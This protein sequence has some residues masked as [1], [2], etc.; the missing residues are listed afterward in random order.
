MGRGVRLE[1]KEEGENIMRM[2]LHRW[3]SGKDSACQCRKCGFDCQVML[4]NFHKKMLGGK[5]L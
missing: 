5:K 2:V 1:I 3:L 4:E